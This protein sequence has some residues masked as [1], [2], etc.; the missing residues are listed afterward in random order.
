LDA[1][2]RAGESLRLYW[3]RLFVRYSA[4]DQFAVIHGIRDRGDA[5]RDLTG[6]CIAALHLAGNRLLAVLRHMPERTAA[7]GVVTLILPTLV[8]VGA[9]AILLRQTLRFIAS[10]EHRTQRQQSQ[11]TKIYRQ[12]IHTVERAGFPKSS[13]ATPFEFSGMVAAKWTAAADAV[14]QLTELYCRGRF[15]RIQLTAEELAHAERQLR[16]LQRLAEMYS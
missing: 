4:K 14:S 1:L 11:I 12:M 15:S 10:P 3:D 7:D 16:A 6:R 2:F 5:I 8:G 13:A 9:L